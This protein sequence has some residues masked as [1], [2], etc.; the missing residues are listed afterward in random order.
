MRIRW[1]NL[2]VIMLV[3]GLFSGVALLAIAPPAH[4][5]AIETVQYAPD[6]A[7][8]VMHAAVV[9]DT[10]PESG[11]GSTIPTSAMIQMALVTVIGSLLTKLIS[12][13][14]SGFSDLGDVGK[15]GI[16]YLSTLLVTVVW[17]LA[18]QDVS[19][20][21]AGAG[22]VALQSLISAATSSIVFKFGA[23]KPPS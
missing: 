4:A 19:P 17:H 3:I 23:N 13:L 12:H 14:W 2:P 15:Y 5:S 11:G 21:L 9:H 18:K 1:R 10:I 7:T 22:A 6:L 16:V 20:D 8:P